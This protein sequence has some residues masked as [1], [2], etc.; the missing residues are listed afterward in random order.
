LPKHGAGLALCTFMAGRT[1]EE[2]RHSGVELTAEEAVAVVQRLIAAIPRAGAP[3]PRLGPP[4]LDNVTL[5]SDGAVDCRACGSTLE[6]SEIGALLEELLPRGR[7]KRVPGAL[8]YSIARA[9]QQVD[10]PPFASLGELSSAL[11]RHE[12]GERSDVLRQLYARGVTGIKEAAALATDRRRSGPSV[13][14]LR[15]QLREADQA[16][17]LRAA[18]P[19]PRPAP[20]PVPP[21]ISPDVD[22]IGGSPDVE[23]LERREHPVNEIVPAHRS[24]A[25]R[26]VLAGAAAAL[27]AFGAGYITVARLQS[28]SHRPLTVSM[29]KPATTAPA[30]GADVEHQPPASNG[31]TSAIAN[32]SPR[33]GDRTGDVVSAASVRPEVSAARAPSS[34]EAEEESPVRAVAPTMG[35][36]FSPAFAPSGTALFFHNGTSSDASSSL[37]AKDLN[38]DDLRVM[39]IL[40]DGSKNYHVQP[41]PDG[42]RVAFD[43]DRDGDRGVYVA[44]RDGTDAHRVSGPGYA[45]VPTWS[46][47]GKSLAY[48]RAE[49][50][51][52]RVWNLWLLDFDEHEYRRL[53]SYRFGQTWSASWFPDGRRIC[54]SHEDRLI[55]RDLEGRSI[56]EF[57]SPVAHSLVRT[58]AVSPDGEHVIFQVSGSGAWL[59]DLSDGAMRRVLTDPSAEEFAWAPDGRRVAFHSRRDGQWGI[60]L[61]TPSMKSD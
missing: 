9:L 51:R 20:V 7:A 23:L 46:P 25:S 38:G 13:T 15:R 40:D 43:S 11:A 47:D 42:T 17:F 26:W 61:M 48:I 52:P 31:V 21:A 19:R 50:D 3:L 53:T 34:A 36:T 16:L 57:A 5:S 29:T 58:P 28:L 12:H 10:A 6:I 2:L 18:A 32:S 45:A 39:T 60:W 49:S 44:N 56:H 8:R 1:L 14:D 24:R 41:S 27:I 37:Q 59:L 22:L 33:P 30:S 35:P 55:V 54:Y 4:S